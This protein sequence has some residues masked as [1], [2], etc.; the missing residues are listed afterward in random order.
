MNN[1]NYSVQN[2]FTEKKNASS[3]YYFNIFY[4]FSGFIALKRI[5]K[6]E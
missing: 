6:A 4:R 5:F 3:L 1:W 2:N